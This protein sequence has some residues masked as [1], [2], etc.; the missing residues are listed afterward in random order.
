MSAMPAIIEPTEVAGRVTAEAAAFTGL[1]EGTIVVCGS[2]DSAVEDYGAGAQTTSPVS[3]L[4]QK[5][6]CGSRSNS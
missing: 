5:P 6:V 3:T 1:K 4:P 2:S